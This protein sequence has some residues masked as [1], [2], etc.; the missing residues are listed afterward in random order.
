[1]TLWDSRTV[2]IWLIATN[3]EEKALRLSW[4]RHSASPWIDKPSYL[5][6]HKRKYQG[7]KFSN[8]PF[9]KCWALP[10]LLN[11]ALMI[12]CFQRRTSWQTVR[13]FARFVCCPSDYFHS[14]KKT[15]E[16]RKMRTHQATKHEWSFS[17]V[18][19]NLKSPPHVME[20]Q[21]AIQVEFSGS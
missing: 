19:C 9:L 3:R 6:Q 21:S 1:M 16:M 7:F 20:W 13:S 2:C 8:T 18:F 12:L 4:S 10:D 15:K 17:D 14:S 11:T 5:N